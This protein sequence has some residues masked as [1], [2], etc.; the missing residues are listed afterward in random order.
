MRNLLKIFCLTLTITLM[1]AR[2][3][4]T[5]CIC[6]NYYDRIKSLDE[7]TGYEFIALVKA[8]SETVNPPTDTTPFRDAT[9]RFKIIEKFKGKNI[10]EVIEEDIQSSCDMGI[11]AGDEWLVFA[12]TH[13]G[14]LIIRAC[15]RNARYR[16][17]DGVRDWHFKRGIQKLEDLRK[18]YGHDQKR[19]R[20]GIDQQHYPDGNPTNG[21]DYDANGKQINI[22]K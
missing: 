11:E 10:S 20:D 6:A 21:A 2:M 16:D 5:A 19:K 9:L 4:V 7:L 18:L 12:L 14:R 13:K 3:S 22:P 1:C 17:K 15:S 8:T